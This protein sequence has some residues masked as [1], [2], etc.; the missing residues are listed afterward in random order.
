MKDF[1]PKGNIKVTLLVY[2]IFVL[3]LLSFSPWTDNPSVASYSEENVRSGEIVFTYVPAFGSYANLR[4]QVLSVKPEDYKVAVY[5]YVSGWWTKPYWARP[6]TPIARDGTWTCD[7]TTGGQDQCATKVIAFLVPKGYNPPLG[8]GQQCLP[9]ELYQY[10]YAEAIRYK[11]ISFAGYDWWVKR[12]C[13]PVGPGPNYFSDS[14]ENISVDPNGY[15]HLKIAQRDERWYCSEVIGD[16]NLGYGTYI[17]TVQGRVDSLDENVVLGLFTWE[18]CVPEHNYREID[19]EFSRWGEAK[20][21]NAQ[22]VVQPW[23]K[24]GNMFRFNIDLAGRPN[25]VTTHVF[26]WNQDSICFCSYYGDFSLVPPKDDIIASWRYTGSNIPPAGA[27]NARI[28]FWLMN[29]IAPTNGQNA[30]IVIKSFQYLPDIT[31]EINFTDFALFATH[32]QET[33][34]SCAGVDLSSDGNIDFDDLKKLTKKWLKT[35]WE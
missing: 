5:I 19:I 12:H 14:N 8:K 30:D 11:K 34:C 9:S 20:N 23:N 1:A 2:P 7:I 26:T 18:D 29:G 31:P 6:L 15:L 4:G 13:N 16:T 22:F 27:E 33:D 35:Y 24:P 10:L 17:F 21:D 3:F 32:W 28:N 25:K